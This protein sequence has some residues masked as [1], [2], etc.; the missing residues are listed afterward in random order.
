[1]PYY[2][3]QDTLH[4]STEN[5]VVQNL[6]ALHTPSLHWKRNYSSN[7]QFKQKEFLHKGALW[8]E[9]QQLFPADAASTHGLGEE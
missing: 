5:K 2:M 7:S 4:E 3:G 1:M 6:Q 8:Q 9:A